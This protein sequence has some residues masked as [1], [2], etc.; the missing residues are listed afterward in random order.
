MSKDISILARQNM[1]SVHHENRGHSK[2]GHTSIHL[3]HYIGGHKYTGT[4]KLDIPLKPLI[5]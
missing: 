2:F 1:V 5:S 4:S 3:S